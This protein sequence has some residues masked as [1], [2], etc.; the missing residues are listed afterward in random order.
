MREFS[1]KQSSYVITYKN[2][3]QKNETY[4]I[5]EKNNAYLLIEM[6]SN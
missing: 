3:K 2:L 5:N 4:F 1:Y 6:S